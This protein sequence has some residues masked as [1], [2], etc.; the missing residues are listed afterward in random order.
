MARSKGITAGIYVRISDDREG[1]ALGVERQE[2][3]CRELAK[4]MGWEVH[5]PIYDDN[6]ISASRFGKKRREGYE[7]LMA[8]IKAGVIQAVI[9]YHPAR[10]HRR[11]REVEGYIDIAER[12]PTHTVRAGRWDLSTPSGRVQARIM[13]AVDA[14]ESE[15]KSD[16]VKR[17]RVQRAQKERKARPGG[18][19]PYGFEKDGVTVRQGEADE[20]LRLT[21][22]V[23][24]WSEPGTEGQS[25]RFLVRDLNERKVP[26]ATGRGMWTSAT[27]RDILMRTRNAG[28]VTYTVEVEDEDGDK[29]QKTETVKAA[30]EPLVPEET[31]RAACA[32]L[33][34]AQRTTT[35]NNGQRGG[36]IKWLGSGLYLCGACDQ[37]TLRVVGSSNNRQTRQARRHYRC[38][39]VNNEN[40]GGHA[41]RE[42]TNLDR[43][44]EGLLVARISDPRV[45]K[46]LRET[47]ADSPNTRALKIELSALGTKED[48]L[49]RN[50]ASDK[51]TERVMNSG[52]E[53]ITKR[54]A[55]IAAQLERAGERTPLDPFRHAK[56]A[57][58]VARIWFGPGGPDGDRIGGLSLG[59][60]RAILDR[61]VT[62]KVLPNPKRVPR[63]ADGG[64]LDT[65]SIVVEPKGKQ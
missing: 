51:I 40:V 64:Y 11:P 7:Q 61:L 16:L 31:W 33:T 30:W 39:G 18:A 38:R 50:Y 59:A 23:V 62:V 4:R 17:S 24:Q 43:Y 65:S 37:P 41:C 32:I 27:L 1:K 20:I 8:D 53:A 36:L 21:E 46:K 52:M 13:A 19:R 22:A 12:V 45:L 60:R 56:D 49:G 10:L 42:A 63:N 35:T 28:L 14:Y 15:Q 34:D 5:E 57:A 25:L 58:D 6:D 47:P 55:E 3:D 9:A 26:T 2:E 29:V 44:V 54:K 48:V